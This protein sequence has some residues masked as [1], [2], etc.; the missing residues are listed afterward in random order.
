MD[1]GEFTISWEDFQ[2]YYGDVA[3]GVPLVKKHPQTRAASSI[4]QPSL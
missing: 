1:G 3:I 2:K 4:R